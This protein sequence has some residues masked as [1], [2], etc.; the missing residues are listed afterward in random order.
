MK[1]LLDRWLQLADVD[2]GDAKE[3]YDFILMDNFFMLCHSD[4]V[5]FI[6]QS[7][8]KSFD[9]M[10][11]RAQVFQDS[12]PNKAVG[13][14]ENVDFVAANI[15]Q[16]QPH[17]RSRS[18]W[19]SESVPNGDRGQDRS[20]SG[21]RSRYHSRDRNRYDSRGPPPQRGQYEG[22]RNERRGR[23][24]SRDRGPMCGR[25]RRTGHTAENCRTLCYKCNV[26]GHMAQDC[27]TVC[28][29]CHN[30]GHTAADCRS[31]TANVATVDEDQT[32]T[33]DRDMQ[34]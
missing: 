26:I 34:S 29:K 15:A 3:L 28:Q 18:R 23:S 4:L 22:P 30:K 14:R 10:L 5:S 20:Q 32:D 25:C 31:V 33:S 1:R 2:K 12:Y 27:K 7:Q 13:R 9:D 21:V 6:K 11:H 24:Q 16:F 17:E 8:P 19:R